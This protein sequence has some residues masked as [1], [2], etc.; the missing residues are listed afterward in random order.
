MIALPLANKGRPA[1]HFAVCSYAE[2][3]PEPLHVE[4]S[5]EHVE[6]C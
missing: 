5:G 3:F 4:V 1:A 2:E 6:A